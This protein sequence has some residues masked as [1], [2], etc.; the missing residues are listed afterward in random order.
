MV[1]MTTGDTQ[2]II[3]A[4]RKH[5][6]LRNELAYVLATAKHETG[7]RMT[8]VRETF[9][10]TDD[11][12]IRILDASYRAGRL[13]WVKSR[14]WIKDKDGKSWLGR[15]YPQVTHKANYEKAK[16]E[17]GIDFIKDPNLMLDSDNAIEVMI[18]GMKEGWF[19]GKKLSDFI[20]LK[21]SDFAGARQIINGTERREIVANYAREYDAALKEMG[22]GVEPKSTKEL[23]KDLKAT[24]PRSKK[25][26]C[27]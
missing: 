20:D 6:L 17:T 8:P 15:G 12:A 18:R 1:V 25:N 13:K 3:A 26:A 21:H 23:I 2:K 19:T 10:K 22:Y 16:K 27:Y 24:T 14:Y 7:A 5:D 11:D 4:G 9:A